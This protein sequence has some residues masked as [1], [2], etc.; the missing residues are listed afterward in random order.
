[1]YNVVDSQAPDSECLYRAHEHSFLVFP[2]CACPGSLMVA[3]LSV[4]D[5][6][7]SA[8]DCN[9]LLIV[10]SRDISFRSP[11]ETVSIMI[12]VWAKYVVCCVPV[13]CNGEGDAKRREPMG[14]RRSGPATK[15]AAAAKKRKGEKHTCVLVSSIFLC[16]EFA[17]VVEEER[18]KVLETFATARVRHITASLGDSV[19]VVSD[20]TSRRVHYVRLIA[21]P[22]RA[23][24]E[25][26]VQKR[27]EASTSSIRR[28]K[29]P[30]TLILRARPSLY[31]PILALLSYVRSQ[32]LQDQF[33]Q[34]GVHDTP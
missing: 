21:N 32:T 5:M 6:M 23:E 15:E 11:L 1:M 10:R 8:R 13:V 24:S 29:L 20:F 19:V 28:S 34:R 3:R 17:G 9:W 26:G 25:N 18:R 4:V 30:R 16:G 31:H 27:V 7:R 33:L 2:P 22:V 14:K 12:F